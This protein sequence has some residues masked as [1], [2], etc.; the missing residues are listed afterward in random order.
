MKHFI[1][2]LAAFYRWMQ[3]NSL[4]NGVVER[5][6]QANSW[7][8]IHLFLWITVHHL[9]VNFLPQITVGQRK[10]S[11]RLDKNL[12]QYGKPDYKNT[13]EWIAWPC[14]SLRLNAF[15]W[16]NNFKERTF[17]V[18][19]VILS[20]LI[21]LCLVNMTRSCFFWLAQD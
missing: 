5:W 11:S 1:L 18:S 9:Y 13:F 8:R 15:W 19:H 21:L 20:S 16:L 10:A 3:R 7:W 14:F 17:L 12:L 6:S 4:L 2:G